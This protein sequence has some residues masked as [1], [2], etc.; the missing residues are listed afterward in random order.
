MDGED[1]INS[2]PK[3]NVVRAPFD[4]DGIKAVALPQN[5]TD[6]A[7]WQWENKKLFAFEETNAASQIVPCEEGV[8]YMRSAFYTA[9]GA[10]G[11]IQVNTLIHLG[12]GNAMDVEMRIEVPESLED[13]PRLGMV[14]EL[15][16]TFNE[17]TYFG[18]GPIENYNDRDAGAPVGLYSDTVDDMFTHYIMPQAS[19]N[20]TGVR[21]LTVEDDNG[22]GLAVYAPD[23]IQFSLSRYSTA[24]L[25]AKRHDYELEPEDRVYLYLDLAQRGAGT[26]TCGPDVYPE[27]RIMPGNY[28]LKLKMLPFKGGSEAIID[29]IRGL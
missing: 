24:Q 23:T 18:R 16:Q 14:L 27:Y 15:P 3:F 4:N 29:K 26:H 8:D 1:I 9:P 22:T 25:Y 6:T 20:R 12:K 13:L 28:C 17:V 2:L 7:L 19:G 5:R 11:G 10:P 21:F